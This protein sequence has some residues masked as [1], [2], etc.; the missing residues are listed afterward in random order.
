MAYIFYAGE[1][2]NFFLEKILYFLDKINIWRYVQLYLPF[3]HIM[4]AFVLRRV[5]FNDFL[6]LENEPLKFATFS[7]LTNRYLPFFLIAILNITNDL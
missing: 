1:K 7:I 5:D 4:I 3:N 2:K 6:N